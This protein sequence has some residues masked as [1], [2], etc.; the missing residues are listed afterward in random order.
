MEIT[1]FGDINL[2]GKSIIIFA[3]YKDGY[4]YCHK[5]SLLLILY[6]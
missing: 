2:D 6:A 5:S 1:V 4:I 3:S